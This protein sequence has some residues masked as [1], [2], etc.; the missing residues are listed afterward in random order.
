MPFS[1]ALWDMTA[2]DPLAY[3]FEGHGSPLPFNRY[4]C[5]PPEFKKTMSAQ[6]ISKKCMQ[7]LPCIGELYHRYKQNVPESKSRQLDRLRL[8]LLARCRDSD[9]DSSSDSTPRLPT[10]L[11]GKRSSQVSVMLDVWTKMSH[12]A[13]KMEKYEIARFSL[14]MQKYLYAN[15]KDIWC[16][17]GVSS[18][19]AKVEVKQ[20]DRFRTRSP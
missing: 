13:C 12:E 14:Q 8:R 11:G 3:R 7:I 17:H 19:R 9:S 16:R 1:G 10:I 20:G 4:M 15:L 2:F 18:S 5:I 6:I